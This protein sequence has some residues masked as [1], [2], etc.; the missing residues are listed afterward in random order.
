MPRHRRPP[1]AH[2]QAEAVIQHGREAGDAE[3]IEPPRR[4]LD[5]QR[6]AIEPAADLGDD[7]RIRIAELEATEAGRGPLDEQLDRR[8]G[9]RLGRR[10][11]CGSRRQRQ[12]R[13]ALHPLALDPQRLPAGG[14]DM[15]PRR[16]LE[17]GLGQ[18]GRRFDHM[19]AA[20]EH[21]QHLLVLEATD[22]AGERTV[23]ANRQA[24]R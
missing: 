12:R 3:G 6:H 15:Q 18:F 4:Q 10:Q 16:A 2:Q 19:L 17:R 13:Q 22:Q 7:R 20:I 8:I 1:A 21:E 11:P 24:E 5:R 23:G 9:Q 14:Q